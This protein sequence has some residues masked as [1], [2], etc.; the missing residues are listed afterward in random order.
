[1][2]QTILKTLEPRGGEGILNLNNVKGRPD[3]AMQF[4]TKKGPPDTDEFGKKIKAE[5]GTRQ[6]GA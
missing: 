4:E 1:M 3:R 2:V 5:R 6:L